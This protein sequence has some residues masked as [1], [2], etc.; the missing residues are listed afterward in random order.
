VISNNLLLVTNGGTASNAFMTAEDDSFPSNSKP[1]NILTFPASFFLD[2]NNDGKRDL[3]VT[4]NAPNA[5]ANFKSVWYYKNI[6]TDASPIFSY[7]QNDLM[8]EDMIETGQGAS[9]VFFD[10]NNDGLMDLVI[11]NEEYYAGSKPVS[12]LSL[13]ENIGT[14]TK[15]AY[16][17]ITR[18]YAGISALSASLA[19]PIQGAHAT[20][21]D[22]DGDGDMD[23][24]VGE[25]DGDLLYYANTAGAG[26]TANFVFITSGYKSIDVGQF[27]TPQLVDIDKD[28]KLDLLIGSRNGSLYFF[29][30]T[31]TLTNPDFAL[32]TSSFGGV[33]T[34]QVG[35]S[36]G[37][38]VPYLYRINGV[39]KL[40]VGAQSGGIYYYGNID[41]NLNGTFSRI[42]TNYQSI[43]EGTFTNISG[44]D[45]NND[46]KIE[47]V[48]GNYGGGV[49]IFSTDLAAPVGITDNEFKNLAISVSPNP[50]NS[51]CL[52]NLGRMVY[53]KSIIVTVY[54]LLGQVQ[55]FF[56]A[57]PNTDVININTNAYADGIYICKL[58]INNQS[59]MLKIVVQH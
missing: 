35:Y 19:T 55:S 1:V 38:S 21:G 58:S 41:N 40:L 52:L 49:S 44:A 25:L 11:G 27:S 37:Y 10:Y 30:N 46:G 43:N 18:D 17:L 28:G 16:K 48:I 57:S 47:L 45:I 53:D 54:N 32:E 6:G 56:S 33:D 34:C 3:L 12:G 36:S 59:K 7:Q 2:V 15:P 20:F 50:S 31:G 26:Q 39:S 5:S 13:Y 23:M 22:I 4:P 14:P 51:N 9:P 8:Q 29:K 24:L 42:D